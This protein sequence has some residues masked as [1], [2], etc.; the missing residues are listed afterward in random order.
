[1][2]AAVADALAAAQHGRAV[3]PR[4]LDGARGSAPWLA[5]LIT[6]PIPLERLD[7]AGEPVAERVVDRVEDDDPARRRAALAGVRERRGDRPFDGAVEVGVV[8][9]DERVLAAQL[10]HRLREP[11]ARGLGDRAPRRRRAR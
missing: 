3:A 10:H 7:G 4:R 9:D 11:A 6:G 8:A 1:M 2:P 5:S